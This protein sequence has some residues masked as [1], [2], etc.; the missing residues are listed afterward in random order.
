MIVGHINYKKGNS[1]TFVI[2]AV[3][4]MYNYFLTVEDMNMSLLEQERV[5][6]SD[7]ACSINSIY[8]N[9]GG[10]GKLHSI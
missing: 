6:Y 9:V 5:L 10:V 2:V 1:E 4:N 8:K 3:Q 7:M